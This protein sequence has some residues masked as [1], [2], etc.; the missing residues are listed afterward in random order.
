MGATLHPLRVANTRQACTPEAVLAL[1]E[2]AF[3]KRL[4]DPRGMLRD[5]RLA[6]VAASKCGSVESQALAKAHLGNAF[7]IVG[8]LR[9]ADA[10]LQEAL[11]LRSACSPLVQ[12]RI[13]EFAASLKIRRRAPN[14]AADLLR[15]AIAIRRAHGG[16]GLAHSLIQ[17]AE[18]YS[19]QGDF[20]VA[21]ETVNQAAI[22]ADESGD[23]SLLLISVHNAAEYLNELRQPQLALT[24]LVRMAPFCASHGSPAFLAHRELVF[25]H[26]RQALGDFHLAEVH[27]RQAITAFQQVGDVGKE[28]AATLELG[29]M[30]NQL[31][32]R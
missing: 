9:E 13:L 17:F 10:A 30:L 25:A 18:T 7:R 26:I 2:R 1:L 21:L 15:E 4:S 28:A 3:A 16:D 32:L 20:I 12:A 5:C 19:E 22:L 8:P 23:L 31:S 6:V 27:Y 14:E 11:G 29:K 24:S